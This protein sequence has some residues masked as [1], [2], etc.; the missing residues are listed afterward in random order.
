MRFKLGA[1]SAAVWPVLT[2]ALAAR[3]HGGCFL[4]AAGSAVSRPTSSLR[5]ASS[6]S[7]PGVKR[8]SI[9][10]HLSEITGTA[11]AAATNSRTEGDQPAAIMSARV[12]FNVK[13]EA[14]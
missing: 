8:L 12:T 5:S 10:S 3:A 7:V 6:I 11:Q 2:R 1:R 9:P 4:L 13:R 14:E